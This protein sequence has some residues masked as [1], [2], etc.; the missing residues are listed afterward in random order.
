MLRLTRFAAVMGMTLLIALS[1]GQAEPSPQANDQ[2]DLIHPLSFG[3]KDG[4]PAVTGCSERIVE[5]PFVHRNLPYPFRGRLLDVGYRESEIIYETASLGFETWGIDIRPPLVEYPGVRYVEGDVIK[6]PFEAESFDVVILL[7]TLEHI[8]L[9]AYGNTAKDPEGD[10]HALQA[11]HRILKPTGRLIL[12]VPF[13]RRGG[14]EWYRVYDH[15]ALRELLSRSGF[16]VETEDYWS[17]EGVR[18]TPTH[19]SAA[20]KIDS[21]TH[22]VQ[23]VACVLAR[24]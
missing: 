2:L 11:V 6:Y 17:K 4:R 1:A 9:M 19:W 7:S 21:V 8:G 16:S 14:A 3:I 12:T 13:G 20:E 5:V 23:A 10:L 24:P 15:Q 18:W 22:H